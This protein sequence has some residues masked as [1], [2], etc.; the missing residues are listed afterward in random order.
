VPELEPHLESLLSTASLAHEEEGSNAGFVELRVR[1]FTALWKAM[2]QA[3]AYQGQ[4]AREV[5]KESVFRMVKSYDLD[6]LEIFLEHL[7]EL[8][9]KHHGAL[10][11]ITELPSEEQE[12]IKDFLQRAKNKAEEH[13]IEKAGKEREEDER[14]RMEE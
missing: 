11:C 3:L 9:I 12:I 2:E 10:E 5:S 4:E 6:V 13:H 7:F 14:H 8:L 1:N